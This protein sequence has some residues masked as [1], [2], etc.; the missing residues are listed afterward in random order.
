MECNRSQLR[1]K[2]AKQYSAEFPI[3]SSARGLPTLSRSVLKSLKFITTPLFA[4]GLWC[5]ISLSSP[6]QPWA[7]KI[8][9]KLFQVPISF[10]LLNPRCWIQGATTTFWD[11][12]EKSPK[13]STLL[14]IREPRTEGLPQRPAR[15]DYKLQRRRGRRRHR[16]GADVIK[17]SGLAQICTPMCRH[18]LQ[19]AS[20]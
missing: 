14:L 1:T 5:A 18:H 11:F 10:F 3:I 16:S 4:R 6:S 12:E 2:C 19:V 8:W 7:S 9:K 17:W 13:N 20:R 15:G